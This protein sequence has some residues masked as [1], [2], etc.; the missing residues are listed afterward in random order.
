MKRFLSIIL[1]VIMIATSVMC[2]SVFAADE[3]TVTING[4]EKAFDATPVI[5]NDRTLV[6]MRGIFEAFGATI[7]WDGATQSVTATV[8]GSKIV[9]QVGK[10]VA[11]VNGQYVDLDAP[12]RLIEGHTM[13]PVRFIAETLG[14]EVNWEDA[15][16]TVVI[17]GEVKAPTTPSTG[18]GDSAGSTGGNAFVPVDDGWAD[19]AVVNFEDGKASPSSG[20]NFWAVKTDGKNANTKNKVVSYSEAGISKPSAGEDFGSNLLAIDINAGETGEYKGSISAGRINDIPADAV[21]YKAGEKYKMSVWVY[22]A[23]GDGAKVTMSAYVGKSTNGFK[24]AATAELKKGEWQRLEL[25]VEATG[26]HEG[27]TTGARFSYE[28]TVNLMYMD[29]LSYEKPGSNA[30]STP[31]PSTPSTPSAPVVDA[32]LPAGGT[33]IATQADLLTG[34]NKKTTLD[35][36]GV[37]KIVATKGEKD[38]SITHTAKTDLSDKIK[39]GNVYMVTFKA[40]LVSGSPYAKLYIQAGKEGGYSK[41]VFALTNYG[42]D[43]TTCYMPFVGPAKAMDGGWGFRFGGETHTTEIKD[44]Q[45][46]DYGTSV[47]IENLPH[48]YVTSGAVAEGLKF[49]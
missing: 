2:V 17:K 29:N 27:Q 37:L 43:W 30:P 47:K 23:D 1:T 3:I 18:T 32:K 8:A 42:S 15:T 40:R 4:E 9:L 33:V 6:P 19:I 20:M 5:I 25:E 21:P 7:E 48:T 31:A 16:R 28:G 39:K 49:N 22:L 45:I 38:T 34:A 44:F 35:E 46:I 12:A 24:K 41:A 14:C 26:D 36:N 13:V 10:V 11:M